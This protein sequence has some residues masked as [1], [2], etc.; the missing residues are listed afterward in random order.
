MTSE[1]TTK[2][3]EG[4]GEA[5]SQ[6]I[7]NFSSDHLNL[8]KN[9]TYVYKNI[10]MSRHLNRRHLTSMYLDPKFPFL[11]KIFVDK[12]RTSRRNS[13][14]K[15]RGRERERTTSKP[16]NRNQKIRKSPWKWV[17][18]LRTVGIAVYNPPKQRNLWLGNTTNVSTIIHNSDCCFCRCCSC[19]CYTTSKTTPPTFVVFFLI[20]Q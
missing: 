12:W 13:K 6:W 8:D 11:T 3:M 1:E 17:K 10:K 19:C 4:G 15:R 14:G 20:N 2:R 7:V 18:N 16:L 9:N 5:S